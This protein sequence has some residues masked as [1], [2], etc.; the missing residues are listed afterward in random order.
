MLNNFIKTLYTVVASIKW[1]LE[2]TEQLGRKTTSLEAT[3][4]TLPKIAFIVRLN[5]KMIFLFDMNLT[6]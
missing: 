3:L 5:H 4:Q 2:C 1:L 6:G